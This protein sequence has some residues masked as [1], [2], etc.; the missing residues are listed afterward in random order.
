[1]L[2]L[3]IHG[4][5]LIHN[6]WDSDDRLLQIRIPSRFIEQ[7]ATESLGINPDGLELVPEFR[8]RDSQI[9]AIAML[10]LSEMKQEN[11]C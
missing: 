7:V 5:K 8:I 6:R 11:C 10:L 9:E 3:I 1:L 4:S 2:K